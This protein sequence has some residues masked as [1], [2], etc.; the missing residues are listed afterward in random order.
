VLFALASSHALDAASDSDLV[1]PGP[2]GGRRR[3][4]LDAVADAR[5]AA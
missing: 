1:F 5:G 3:E 4:D 2:D